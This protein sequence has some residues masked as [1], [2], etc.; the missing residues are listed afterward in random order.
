MESQTLIYE[1]LVRHPPTCGT[2]QGNVFAFKT[3]L[4]NYFKI[5][6]SRCFNI[7][8]MFMH[9]PYRFP[10]NLGNDH[11]LALMPASGTSLMYC[12]LFNMTVF[13]EIKAFILNLYNALLNYERRICFDQTQIYPV[14]YS[15]NNVDNV[16]PFWCHLKKACCVMHLVKCAK[17]LLDS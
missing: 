12:I 1:L 16:E 13:R 9:N 3:S 2:S 14:Y 8:F 15:G 6:L 4:S 17:C 10:Y 11:Y 5:R 7:I